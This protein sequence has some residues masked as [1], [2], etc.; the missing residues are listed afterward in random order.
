MENLA[1]CSSSGVIFSVFGHAG[2]TPQ[3]YFVLYSF[4]SGMGPNFSVES[5]LWA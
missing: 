4:R 5:S 2:L 1:T 3:E